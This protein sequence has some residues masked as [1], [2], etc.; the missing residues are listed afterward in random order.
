MLDVLSVKAFRTLFTAQIVALLG[1][2]LLTVALGLLA[3]DLAGDRAGLVLGTV[4]TVKMIAY[5]GLSPFMAAIATRLPRRGFL[6]TLDLARGAVALCLPFVDQIW[7]VYLLVFI[8]QA[9]S[10]GF[11]PA[12]QATIPDILPDEDQYTRALSLSRLAYDLENIAS[13]ALAALLL[14]VL[15]FSALFLGTVGGFVMSAG[16]IFRVR[17]PDRTAKTTQGFTSRLT[18]GLRIYLATPRLRGFLGLN[19]AASSVG[20]MVLVNTVVLV[21]GTLSLSE[22]EVALT[23]A[24]FGAGSIM[25]ALLLPRIL[26]HIPDRPVMLAGASLAIAGLTGLAVWIEMS[27]LSWAVLLAAWLVVGLGYSAV[28]TPSGRLLRRSSQAEDRPAVFAAQFTLSHACWLLAYPLAGWLMTVA[29]AVTACLV[30]SAVAVAGALTAVWMWPA[31]DPEILD[32]DHPDLPSD[33]PHLR[34][35][36][37]HRHAFTIDDLHPDWPRQG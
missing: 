16:L 37:P 15:P 10:A 13:P 31:N 11:T 36:T 7:Q 8:L 25:A 30:L 22:T 29:G 28:L 17:L 14:V 34:G 9:A 6:V 1:T 3:F 33:H 35:R 32:H 20:A 5:V 23:M 4:F 2:G 24:A 18:K 12:F 26:E 27:G 21:Q 19:L